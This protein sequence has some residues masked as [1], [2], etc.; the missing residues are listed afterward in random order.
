MASSVGMLFAEQALMLL[1]S[2]LRVALED[3]DENLAR[4]IEKSIRELEVAREQATEVQK[5]Q[6]DELRKRVGR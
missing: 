3:G 5:Q 6:L 4:V 1:I 2:G